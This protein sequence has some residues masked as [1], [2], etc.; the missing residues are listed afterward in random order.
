[1]F[2]VDYVD[3]GNGDDVISVVMATAAATAAISVS[4]LCFLITLISNN[5]ENWKKN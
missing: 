5:I 1:M 3:G 2:V 4:D